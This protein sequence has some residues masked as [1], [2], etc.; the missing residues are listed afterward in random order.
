MQPIH[1]LL[2]RIRWDKAFARGEFELAYVD[3]QRD[4]LVHVKLEDVFHDPEDHFRIGVID[5]DGNVQHIPYHRVRELRK[6]G[7]LIWQR[8]D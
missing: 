3:H 1:E 8:D 7:E 4:A 5:E 2:N 6:N